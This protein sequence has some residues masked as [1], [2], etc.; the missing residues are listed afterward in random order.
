MSSYKKLT[1]FFDTARWFYK[2]ALSRRTV[3]SVCSIG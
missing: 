1:F 3:K 2:P